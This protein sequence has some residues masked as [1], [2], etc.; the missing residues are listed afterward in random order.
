M[1]VILHKFRNHQVIQETEILILGSFNPDIPD[2]PTFFYGRHKNNLWQ[3]LPGCWIIPSLRYSPLHDKKAF[4][5]KYK[6]DFADLIASVDVEE[7]QHA[8]FLD[9]YIDPRVETWKNIIELITQLPK[10]KAVYFTRKTFGG[11]PNIHNKI[12]EI[13]NHCQQVGIRFCLLETPARFV[14]ADK[15]QQWI[16]TIINQRTC[17]QP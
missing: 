8:N 12:I 2:G 13:I 10:L 14:N 1:P 17:L 5:V 4:M 3:L 15:Q 16:S 7:G 6:I 11:I 9:T